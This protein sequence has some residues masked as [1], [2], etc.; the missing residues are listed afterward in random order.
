VQP[1]V[2]PVGRTAW[3]RDVDGRHSAERAYVL[4]HSPLASLALIGCARKARLASHCKAR[5]LADVAF[6]R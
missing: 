2:I 6:G 3:I 4:A 5:V 1:V